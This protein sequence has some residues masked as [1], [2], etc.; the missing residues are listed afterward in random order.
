[1]ISETALDQYL[2]GVLKGG[3][4]KLYW[5]TSRAMDDPDQKHNWINAQRRR[6]AYLHYSTKRTILSNCNETIH[7]SKTN[8]TEWCVLIAYTAKR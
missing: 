3:R 5:E 7:T 1:M 4:C 6:R 2:G 8:N